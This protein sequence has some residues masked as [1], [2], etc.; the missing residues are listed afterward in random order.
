MF[1][2]TGMILFLL[3]RDVLWPAKLK[4]QLFILFYMKTWALKWNERKSVG[5]K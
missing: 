5:N 3:N 1:Q 4:I 2:F